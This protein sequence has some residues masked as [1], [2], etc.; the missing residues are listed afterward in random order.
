MY[1]KVIEGR[2]KHGIFLRLTNLPNTIK[3]NNVLW[4]EKKYN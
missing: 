2:V 4:K 3:Q 1:K